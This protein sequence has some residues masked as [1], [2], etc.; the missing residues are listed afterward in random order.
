MNKNIL[1]QPRTRKQA[2]VRRLFL[3]KIFFFALSGFS[4]FHSEQKLLNTARKKE[5]V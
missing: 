4:D 1:T 2:T 3:F 5:I